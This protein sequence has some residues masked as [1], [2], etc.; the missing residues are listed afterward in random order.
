MTPAIADELKIPRER[1]AK[2][3][4]TT[5]PDCLQKISRYFHVSIDLLLSLISAGFPY[6][7]FIATRGK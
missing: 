7:N 4:G 2:Y 1:Y 3:E 5:D 6:E